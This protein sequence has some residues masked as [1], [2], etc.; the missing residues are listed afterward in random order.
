MLRNKKIIL[1]ILAIIISVILLI[2]LFPLLKPSEEVTII[3]SPELQSQPEFMN[4][5]ELEAAGLPLDSKIQ[6]FKR[7]ENNEVEVYRIIRQESDV[8]YDVEEFKSDY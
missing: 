4:A 6:I 8:I 5:D 3:M 7:N 1:I 2:I